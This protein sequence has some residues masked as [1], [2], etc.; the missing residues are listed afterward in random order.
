MG[1]RASLTSYRL[2]T[3]NK[4]HNTTIKTLEHKY[5]FHVCCPQSIQVTLCQDHLKVNVVVFDVKKMIASLFNDP[6][7]NNYDNLVVK[8]PNQFSKYV[9]SDNRYGKVNS[10]SWYNTAY[11]KCVKDKETDFLCPLILASKKTT[12]LEM[13]YLHFDALFLTTSIFNLEVSFIMWHITPCSLYK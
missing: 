7:I 13:G 5:N 11:S 4:N 12:L 1:I 3:K 2:D 8:K 10:G 9:P 6:V